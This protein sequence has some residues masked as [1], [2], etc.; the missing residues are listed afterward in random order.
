M[1]SLVSCPL[2]NGSVPDETV[3]PH[4]SPPSERDFYNGYTWCLNAY[5]TIRQA[6]IHLRDELAKLDVAL[7][8]W[9]RE[10]VL[11]NI[12]LLSCGITSSL[13]DYLHGTKYRLPWLLGKLPLS[14]LLLKA[15]QKTADR[16]WS[17]HCKHV[18]Q[19][20]ERWNRTFADFL[21]L[22]MA[23]TTATVEFGL[24]WK[25][26]AALLPPPLC[27][28]LQERQLKVPSGFRRQDLTH[29]DVM[30]LGRRFIAD[31]PDRKAPLLV[32]GLRTS[33]SYLAPVLQAFLRNEGFATVA[34]MTLRPQQ[35]T[36]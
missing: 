14:G 27:R 31:H 26:L 16:R 35:G 19:W 1:M 25:H 6:V 10:E 2:D 18:L 21:A 30:T 29:Q 9:Q 22:L 24:V 36:T 34:M 13:E 28:A 20:K 32:V 7:E 23:E 17:L 5:P 8:P 33:G 3:D 15:V 4:L 12:Y 11:T